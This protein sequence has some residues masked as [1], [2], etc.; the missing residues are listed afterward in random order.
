M[1]K[2]TVSVLSSNM[3]TSWVQRH[4]S[5]QSGRATA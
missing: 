3:R 4:R 5:I 2:R 1:M